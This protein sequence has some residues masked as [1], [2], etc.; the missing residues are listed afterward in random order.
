MRQRIRLPSEDE[1]RKAPQSSHRTTAAETIHQDTPVSRVLQLQQNFGNAAAQRMLDHRQ[2][3]HGR[4][5]G[6]IA[7]KPQLMRKA[8]SSPTSG[9]GAALASG[10]QAVQRWPW[11]D[12]D[13]EANEQPGGGNAVSGT[14]A[15]ISEDQPQNGPTQMAQQGG[16]EG[17]FFG[18][19]WPFGGGD[20]KDDEKGDDSGWLPSMPDRPDWFPSDWW[21][22]GGDNKQPGGEGPQPG[23]EGPG[24]EMPPGVDPSELIN[25][26]ISGHIA[27]GPREIGVG[28]IGCLS[29]DDANASNTVLSPNGERRIPVVFKPKFEMNVH[30]SGNAPASPETWAN[31][32]TGATVFT[33]DAVVQDNAIA[34]PLGA[35]FPSF[36]VKNIDWQYDSGSDT[37]EINCVFRIEVIW[38]VTGGGA[39]EVKS[40]DQAGLTFDEMLRAADDF[41]FIAGLK[42]SGSRKFGFWNPD[43]TAQHEM[44]HV[45][46]LQNLI[47]DAQ[48]DFMDA[49]M[50]LDVTSP[51]FYR[52]MGFTDGDK[53]AT[54]SE[55]AGLLEKAKKGAM[56]IMK[57]KWT[58]RGIEG[59]AYAALSA[60]NQQLAD[61]LR[62]RARKIPMP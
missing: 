20:K 53:K 46:Q 36:Q 29:S 61:A 25:P 42:D 60:S 32:G 35:T 30:E 6:C 44:V 23:G 51:P 3:G 21:P 45:D 56:S 1:A 9:M 8:A 48:S 31:I 7:C 62:D 24:V 47:P 16:S 18:D 15:S 17:S 5:C 28:A 33:E 39:K 26:P 19:W 27:N 14:I 22:F 12:D 2:D 55:I 37:I 58:N 49:V 10:G 43:L 4:A 41:E 40:A 11:D 50:S 59:P 54:E 52:S 57:A 38:G 34:T 13:K